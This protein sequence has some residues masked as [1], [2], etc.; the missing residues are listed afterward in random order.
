MDLWVVAAAAGAGYIAKNIR[1]LSSDEKEY[2]AAGPSHMYS[3][4]T[5]QSESTNFLQQ[6]REK[7]CPLR[8]P[9]RKIPRHDSSKYFPE[10]SRVTISRNKEESTRL[11]DDCKTGLEPKGSLNFDGSGKRGDL[12]RVSKKK[13]SVSKK[14]SLCSCGP[15]TSLGRCLDENEGLY[16]SVSSDKPLFDTDLTQV[17]DGPGCSSAILGLEGCRDEPT[18]K[19]ESKEGP[20][21]MLLFV[22][23]MI[24]GILSATIAWKTEVDK[25]NKQLKQMQNLVEDLH[26]ELD[27][28]DTLLV[29]DITDEGYYLSAVNHDT[30]LSTKEPIAS[31]CGAEVNKPEKND[32]LKANDRYTE[33][34]ELM[35]KIESELEAELEMLE[36]NMKASSLERISV[37]EVSPDFEP[38]T[39]QGE[40]ASTANY[41]VS[42]WELR[43]RLHELI[44]SRLKKHINKLE[45]ALVDTQRLSDRIES[46]ENKFHYHS[47][48]ESS[49]CARDEHDEGENEFSGKNLSA[50]YVDAY[51]ESNADLLAFTER[52]EEHDNM[53][54]STCFMS[55]EDLECSDEL[56]MLLIEQIVER[57]KS[58]YSGLNFEN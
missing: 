56:E 46:R 39:V 57:R 1:N 54:R 28:K 26:E 53:Q 3:H 21:T 36:N 49:S 4:T 8:R 7:T 40:L 17:V 15:V 10:V 35:S 55:D 44:E 33:N 11:F 51:E 22:T 42:P 52:D 6:L 34:L 45:T 5:T 37:V 47:E 43:L 9:E 32:G 20:G 25:L 50:N 38:D 19:D 27:M 16:S 30:P 41:A 23:G 18:E 29:K 31:P 48:T 2:P 24:I 12:R 13:L 58:G 14:C